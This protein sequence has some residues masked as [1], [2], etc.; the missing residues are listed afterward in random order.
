MSRKR[1]YVVYR[2]ESNSDDYATTAYARMIAVSA[3]GRR[4]I[5]I[6]CSPT[7][8]KAG[9]GLED[10]LEPLQMDNW[11]PTLGDDFVFDDEIEPQPVMVVKVPAKR[12]ANSDAPLHEWMGVNERVGFCEEYLLKELRLEGRGSLTTTPC[13]CSDINNNIVQERLY[14]CEDCYGP[15]IL[16]KSCCLLK[17]ARHPLHI[18]YK[19]NGTYFEH[20]SLADMGLRVQLGHEGM[21]CLRPQRGHIS[22]V[23]IHTNAI[24]RVNIDFCGCHQR[25]SHR[26]QLLRCKW[27]PATPHFPQSACTRQVLEFFLILAW[28]SKLSGY[29]FYTKFMRMV[30]Q[31]R[32]IKLMKRAG[33]GNITGGIYDTEPGALAIKCPA[34]PQP[35]INLP[36]DWDKVEGSMK[37]LYYLIIAMDANFRLKN[38]NRASSIADPGLHTGLAY[39]VPDKFYTEHILKNASQADIST[40]SG[41]KTLA[42]AESKYSNGLQLTGVG[43]C[44]CAHHELVRPQGVGD[45][46]KGERYA[47]MDFIFFSSIMPLLLLTVVIS[48][49]IACQWKLNLMKRMNELPEHLRMPAAVALVAFMF[50]IPKFHCPAHEEKC[51]IPHSLNLM[52]GVGRTDG[53]GIER[54]WAEMNCVANSTKEMGTGYQHDVLDDHFGHHNWRKYAGLGLSLRKKL[55]NAVKEQGRHQSFLRDFNLVIDDAHRGEWTAMIEA[56]ERDKS[57]PNPYVHIKI[58]DYGSTGLS[59]AQICANLTDDEKI[60]ISNGRQL[61][62]EVTPSS[63]IN[64]GL[65]LE[66]AQQRI[67]Y[68]LTRSLSANGHTELNQRRITLQQ[69][70]AR[71]RVIQRVYMV[72]VEGWI[73]EQDMNSSEEV[74]DES[75]WLPST[76]PPS[77]RDLLC[78]NNIAHIEAELRKGQCRDSLDK[79]CRQLHTKSHFVKHCNLDL[80]RQQANTRAN[81][82]LTRL[83]SKINAA[84]EKYR[85]AR[86]AS[87]ELVGIS[88]L[89]REFQSLEAKD[90]VAPVDTVSGVRST[91]GM[92]G[93]R[94]TSCGLGQGYQTTSWIWSVSGVRDHE[95][96]AGLNDVLR[97]EWAKSCARAQ[98]WSEEVLLLKEEMRRTRQ[99][100]AWRAEQWQSITDLSHKDTQIVAGAIAYAHRQAA[101]QHALLSRF[102]FL[103]TNGAAADITAATDELAEYFAGDE[104]NFDD[105]EG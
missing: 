75:L 100:L 55:L 88:K 96:D 91:T 67:K 41:F 14:H 62:H 35:G 90:I 5:T 93:R 101:V 56:W 24:H 1:K 58:T 17:H 66:D 16:C 76:L 38:R 30:R 79:L 46:Q 32:H 50:G 77:D 97:V 51:A 8:F 70:L 92:R 6:P 40:C 99:F 102:T 63:F 4:Q 9:D 44:L 34:C 71:F 57:S 21:P 54:N 31:F 37:F 105:D 64:M 86:S 85:V 11:E 27:Y 15:E 89:D 68:D 10:Q 29:E 78:T 87:L 19:W 33:R 94:D 83:N 95:S 52:P 25:V 47:N 22:F 18:I 61:P 81:S 26:Q 73:E 53:E 42:H 13:S 74:E 69:Q 36:E 28:S 104:V 43:L 23:M 49:D 3:G 20:S 12:Y 7:K 103:W 45:L 39:F 98:R 72:G 82:S 60:S 84:A 48:Y 65:V 59:E 2:D 80:R